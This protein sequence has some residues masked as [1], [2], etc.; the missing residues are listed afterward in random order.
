MIMAFVGV[1]ILQFTSS[2]ARHTARSFMDT[3]ASLALRAATE[4][5]IMAIQA[6]NYSNNSR[7]SEINLTFPEFYANIKFHYFTPS[8]KS[9]DDD[10]TYEDT[11][12]T[13]MT[14]L[15]YVTVRS[16]N[17]NLHIRKVRFTLQNP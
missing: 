5:A 15:I 8:C 1:M 13:N 11:N 7:I 14:S 2:S 12:D 3:K 6:R 9:T 4:Y 17:P 16:K 10:C